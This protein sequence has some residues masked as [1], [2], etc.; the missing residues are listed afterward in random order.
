MPDRPDN[1][2][3]LALSTAPPAQR[4]NHDGETV[5]FMVTECQQWPWHPAPVPSALPI[6]QVWGWLFVPDGRCAVLLDTTYWLPLLPGGKIEQADGGDPTRCLIRETREEAQAALADPCYLGYVYDAEGT[7]FGGG[8]PYA[9]VR[10]AARVTHIA[11]A[12]PDPAGRSLLRLLAPPRQAVELFG[13]GE[14]AHLQ[15]EA[16]ER[17]ACDRWGLR[18]TPGAKVEEI[19][20]QGMAW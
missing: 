12:A 18:L 9:R 14:Q 10:Y 17:I 19:P 8:G 15:A 7:V 11:A 16:A 13:W 5:P 3:P 6:R 1:R 4:H 2:S 20:R